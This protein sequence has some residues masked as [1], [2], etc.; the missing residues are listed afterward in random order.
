M[1]VMVAPC[2]RWS[3]SITWACFESRA[4]DFGDSCRA[5][6]LVFLRLAASTRR[7]GRLG[8]RSLGLVRLLSLPLGNAR[9]NADRR[10][11]VRR[12]AE[13]QRT[14]VIVTPPYRQR[15]AGGDFFDQAFAQ[16]LADGFL[17]GA[18]LEIGREF[19]CTLRVLCGGGQQHELRI[20]E[21]VR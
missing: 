16:E 18:A 10:K 14:P 4:A 11:A 15:A 12:D 8:A 6:S 20:G 3:I 9:L 2:W 7:E 19:N 5:S 1:A 21:F 17:G 13:R